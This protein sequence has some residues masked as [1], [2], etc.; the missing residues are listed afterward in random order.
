MYFCLFV[1]EN[2]LKTKNK[3]VYR[4]SFDCLDDDVE[5]GFFVATIKDHETGKIVYKSQSETLEGVF[6]LDNVAASSSYDICF[7][8]KYPDD[9]PEN[10]IDVGFMI[11]VQSTPRSLEDGEIGPDTERALKLINRASDIRQDW[12]T[13]LDHLGFVRSREGYHLNMNAAIMQRLS[14]WT[15]IEAFVVIGVATGQVLYW[16]KFFET[17]RY[18]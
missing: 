11:R 5:V 14:Y 7:H 6:K 13:M 4:G 15:Y 8:N 10:I 9:D 12:N 17:R 1:L 3:I 16:R 2:E 18:L